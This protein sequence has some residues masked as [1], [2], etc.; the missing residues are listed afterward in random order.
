[1]R[2]ALVILASL[3]TAAPAVAEVPGKISFSARLVDEESGDAVTGAHQLSFELFDRATAGAS[4]WQESREITVE[5]GV[6]FTSLGETT[7]LGPTVVDGRAL[8]L[9]VKLDNVAMEPR[10]ALDSVPYAITAGS[11]G[12]VTAPQKRVTG[13]C[14]TGNFIIAI[15]DDG[16]VVC[17]PDLSGSGD[18]TAVL[19]GSGLEGGGSTGDLTLSLITSCQANEILK[20]NGSAWACAIDQG[21]GNTGDI[22]AVTVGPAGGLQG[23]G[24]SGDVALSLLSTCAM[25]QVLKWNGASWTC[26]NDVDT[27]TNSGG[28]ISSVTTAAG[29]GLQ[30]GASAGDAMLTLLTTCSSG[31]LLKWS[32]TAWACASDIDTDTNAGGDITD[33]GAGNGLTGGGASGVV[34]LDVGEGTGI[35]V[36]GNAVALD[37]VYTDGRYVNVTGDTLTGSLAMGGNRITG[38]GCP[39]GYTSAGPG[40]CVE[41][42]D[43]QPFTFAGCANRCRA[44]G[45]HVC[46]SAEMRGVLSSGAISSADLLLDWIDDQD[47]PDSAL[48]VDSTTDVN[49]LEGSRA[50]TS[51]SYCRCC[52]SVE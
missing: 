52:A 49:A 14:G 28:D 16:T 12:G 4:V 40:L 10:I 22:T 29:S 19:A 50:T 35:D 25:G 33:V 20:W 8:W 26:A 7:P 9:E 47:A 3:A 38:R 6:V 44:V 45:T 46:S 32:G 39:T 51:A 23:G 11:V 42:V 21:S 5:D 31:Q 27:D 37:T 2:R 43:A 1:M 13:T 30:G 18:V 48:Y 34:N 24:A 41:T 36:T 15:N 17:A